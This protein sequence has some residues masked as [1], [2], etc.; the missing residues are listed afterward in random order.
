MSTTG[1]FD[2]FGKYNK[3]KERTRKAKAT[4][5]SLA[6]RSMVARAF[7]TQGFTNH[8]KQAKLKHSLVPMSDNWA[9]L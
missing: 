4:T 1:P 6:P 8:Q 9:F 2:C 5:S 7:S 3:A